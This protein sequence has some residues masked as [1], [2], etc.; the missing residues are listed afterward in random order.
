MMRTVAFP[1]AR[2][3]SR[4]GGRCSS[5]TW[6]CGPVLIARLVAII[7]AAT[8][9]GVEGL[10]ALGLGGS[11]PRSTPLRR[12]P[13]FSTVLGGVVRGSGVPACPHHLEP[14][15][16]EDPDRV[17]VTLAAGTSRGVEEVETPWGTDEAP[18]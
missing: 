16:R 9:V 3:D 8:S 13:P 7:L 18:E 1:Q 5:S 4:V 2:R 17:G 15:P 11:S 10:G 6:L 12:E 14:C